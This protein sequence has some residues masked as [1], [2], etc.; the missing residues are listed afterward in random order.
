MWN[1]FLRT[2][3]LRLCQRIAFHDHSMHIRIGDT[4]VKNDG[5]PVC[6]V[7]MV[8]GEDGG[9]CASPEACPLRIAFEIDPDLL[10]FL[11]DPRKNFMIRPVTDDAPVRVMEWIVL[12]HIVIGEAV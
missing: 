7:Q 12:I 11:K 3:Y 1:L 8:G 5:I 2:F 4:A 6:F 9:E 10:I